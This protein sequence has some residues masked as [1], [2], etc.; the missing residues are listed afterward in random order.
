MPD[1]QKSTCGSPERSEGTT[2][3]CREQ[4]LNLHAFRH[5]ILS[6]A[7]LPIPPSRHFVFNSFR[8]AKVTVVEL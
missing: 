4:D 8:K 6:P 7:R 3:W 1:E 5:W 2:T